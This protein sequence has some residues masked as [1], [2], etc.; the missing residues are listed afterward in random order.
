M[1]V[2]PFRPW[3]IALVNNSQLYPFHAEI[4]WEHKRLRLTLPAI[5]FHEKG[6]YK[7]LFADPSYPYTLMR[8]WLVPRKI[9]RNEDNLIQQIEFDFSH[10][11]AN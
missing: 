6:R 9:E 5:A 4:S 8:T 3:K 2:S 1:P 7:A 11:Q 10:R